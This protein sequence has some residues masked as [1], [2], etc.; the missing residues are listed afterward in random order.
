MRIRKLALAFALAV[1]A[2][3][4]QAVLE[5]V[6]PV[7]VAPNIGGFPEWYQ[8]TTGL[9]LEFCDPK[10][11]SELAGSWCLLLPGDVPA[12]PEVFPGAFGDEHFYWAAGASAPRAD[13]GKALLT[14][15]TEAAFAVGSARPGDQVTFARIRVSIS[16]VP[17]TGTY[18][19]IH[20]FG[21]EVVEGV[22]GDRIFYTEDIGIGAPGDFS[23]AL[24]SRLGPFLLPSAAPGGVEMP[25]LTAANPTPDVDPAH[26]GG[27]FAPTP[28]PGTGKAYIADPARIGPVTGSALP[29]F[30]DSA[31][32]QRN[33]NI[34][35][36]EGPAGWVAET[37]GFSLMGR[38]MTGTLPGRI[39]VGRASYTRSAVGQKVDVFASAVETTQGR[40]PTQPRPAGVTPQ[41]TFF[42]APCGGVV[43]PVTGA[44]APPYTAPAGAVETQMY[45]IPGGI[46]WGG[47]LQSAAIPAAVC[48]KDGVARDANG[49]VVPVYVNKQVSD[50]VYISQALFDQAS[51]T[52]TVSA[53]SSDELSPPRLS[54]TYAGYRGDLVNGQITVQG[55]IATPES[56]RVV[57]SAKGVDQ[58]PVKTTFNLTPPAN[59]P[60]AANDSAVVL[61]DCAP[62][63]STT[64]CVTPLVIDVLAND[65]GVT[66]GTVN[67]VSG[68][69]LGTA[70]VNPD[71]TVSY[72]P[73]LNASGTDQF[74]YT[75]T[76]GTQVSNTG[77]A[78]INI[79]PVNDL[80]TA[81]GDSANT[82]AGVS[83]ALN[84]LAN[85]I[86]PDG[87]ADLVAALG[88]TQT[89]GP[90]AATFAVSGGIINLVAPTAGTYTFSYRA[91]DAANAVSANAATLT[92]QVAAT[93]T[94]SFARTE[95]V[96]SKTQLKAQGNLSPAV[97]QTVTVEF[98]DAA[99][100]VLGL[101]GTTT[102]DNLG[103]WAV[104][105]TVALPTGATAL[106]ATTSNGTSRTANISFK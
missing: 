41:L 43:D 75:V 27:V 57:S 87:A 3:Q 67:V 47:Q 29:D 14:L 100:T 99:G 1:A 39:D 15:A 33:H 103:G 17:F 94:L 40:L 60:V 8:D 19:I 68:T 63:A 2:G 49:N 9:A 13:G 82:V 102:V 55:L 86:D 5:R 53:T 11:A 12:V 84:V 34:F 70:V 25:A 89:G 54:L 6:G 65:S 101:G 76:L 98:V 71:G 85:D 31:G 10:N 73:N 91:Q 59:L 32:A 105:T 106:K 18:R 28:Y 23:G 26:F 45:S 20:P 77:T 38:V 56:V 78:T 35:R 42:N 81:V 88:V 51:G 7:G 79:T 95:Y 36:I 96:R 16:P 22:A 24:N 37:T 64:A 90:A 74:T 97:G 92:V 52:L 104:A 69:R 83:T 62:T 80:P 46:H 72:T 93:E 66:G 21:E 44:V 4:S 48:V 30:T 58:D 50:E 61:E